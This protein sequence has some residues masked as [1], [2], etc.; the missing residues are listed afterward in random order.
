M[1]R[2]KSAGDRVE[3]QRKIM[4]E[5]NHYDSLSKEQGQ[6]NQQIDEFENKMRSLLRQEAEYYHELAQE[7]LY[8]NRKQE[9]LH[10]IQQ[11]VNRMSQN[12]NELVE[13]GY[14][15]AKK[16]SQDKV[17]RLQKERNQLPWD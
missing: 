6:V 17:E 15:N 11:T 14:V 8:F 12:Q 2:D 7:D 1:A 4:A 3:L 13:L 9:E 10:E 16:E 5:E